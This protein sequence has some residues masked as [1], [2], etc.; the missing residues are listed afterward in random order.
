MPH[1]AH[2]LERLDR[3][4]RKH[5]ELALGLYRDHELVRYILSHTR[6]AEGVER[7]AIALEEGSQGPHIIVARSGAFVTCLGRGMST[8]ALPIVTRAHLDGLASKFQRVRE[9]LELARKRGVDETRLLD[10][11]E[12]AGPGI[13]RED[14]LAASAILGP[15]VP[16]LFGVYSDWATAIQELHPL[17]Q[18]TRR[19]AVPQK[20]RAER[21]LA[22]G[23]WAC[24]HAA[25]ILVDSAS[26]EWVREWASFPEHNTGS[27]WSV[28]VSQGPFPFAMRAA[29]LAGRLGKPMLASYKE[30]FARPGHAI[31]LRE[32]GLGLACMA[33]RHGALRNEALKVL[34]SPPV[35]DGKDPSEL[36]PQYTFFAE[37]AA[38]VEAKED[39]LRAEALDLGRKMVVERTLEAP[40]GSP[41]RFTDAGQVPDDLALPALFSLWYDA[42]NGE[43]AG[44]LTLIGVVAAAQAR[45]E[46]FY[47]PSAAIHA[48]VSHDL[49]DLED[50]GQS[51]VE[52]HHRLL[53]TQKTVVRGVRPGRN[54]P[55]P[56]GSG[57][58]YKKCHGR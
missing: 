50:A 6:L 13:T 2:F 53:G 30:R 46:D 11:I 5:V 42:L 41:Y 40:E 57:R 10:R 33:L 43:R 23:A 4:D 34:R 45:A 7:I 9:G 16:L 56:C 54:D 1:D 8:G 49:R 26:R 14:F 24:A 38:L 35:A 44:D 12:S 27:A 52:M 39:S 28:L 51:M 3:V 29:W 20:T 47:Y 31:E 55:C 17:L 21:D 15:A 32:A 18:T 19:S 25:I 22:R 36:A 37:L 48:M 58:K